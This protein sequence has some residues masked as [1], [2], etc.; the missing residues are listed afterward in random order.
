[1]NMNVADAT[2][3]GTLYFVVGDGKAFVLRIPT[4]EDSIWLRE[5]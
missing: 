5:Y 2:S 4:P 3:I 1:M